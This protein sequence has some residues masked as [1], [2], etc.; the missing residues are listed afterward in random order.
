MKKLPRSFYLRP[1]ITI[2]K[3]LLG[4]YLVRRIKG[5]TL[6]GKIVETEAYLGEQDPAS[7]A[8]RGRTD[9]NKV[10]FRE[11]GFLYV[12]FTYG[13]HY[14]CNIVT[15]NEGKARAVLLRALEPV[16]GIDIMRTNRINARN[17]LVSAEVLPPGKHKQ[18]EMFS[19]ANGPAKLCAALAIGREENGTDLLGNEIYL[20][21]GEPLHSSRSVVATTRIGIK[22]AVDKR[23]RFYIRG[24]SFVSRK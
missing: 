12:Y 2:A 8:Y 20:T 11:G 3:D 6:V 4:R 14:C 16:R 23:W 18:D 13:M 17:R 21:Q 5:K 15:E 9:R 10:M 19:L 7:H 1:T 24:S 22:E